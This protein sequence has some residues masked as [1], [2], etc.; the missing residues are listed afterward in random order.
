MNT[1]CE[2]V[3][4][5]REIDLLQEIYESPVAEFV[6]VFGRRRIGKTYLVDKFFAG[7]YDFYMTGIY[8]GTRREQLANFAHQL[9]YYSH[10]EQKTPKDWMEAFFMLRKYAD[11]LKDKKRIVIFIDEMP[12]LD[13]HNA[14]FLKAF[15]LFW[16][17]WASKQ[18]RLKLIVCGSATTWMTNTLLGN[19]GGLHNRV[20]RSIYLRPFNLSDTEEFLT[21]RGFQMQRFQIAELYMVMGGTPFYLNMLNRSKSVAQNIDELFF[22]ANAPLRSEYGFL[23]K[24][25]FKESSLYRRVVEALAKKLKGMTRSELIEELKVEDSGYVSTVLS[26]LCNCDFIRKY[27]AFGKTDR[28][29]M[30]QLTDLYSLFYLKFVKNYHGE[31]EQYW[32]HRQMDIS[33]WEGYAFEQVC[34]HHIPQIKR[35][36]GISGILSNVCT[37]ACRPFVDENG[38]KQPGAQIDLVIERGDKTVNLCEMKFASHPYSVSSDYSA[39]LAKRRELFRQITGTRSTLHLTMIT[40]YGVEH[41]AGWQTIQ[42]EVVLDDLFGRE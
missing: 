17:E 6:A 29:S 11:T 20:T 26:D 19:K 22:S 10:A 15:E 24:S 4:R 42:S 34:L 35:K 27:S 33:S 3:G 28:D 12:W 25:L 9:E 41:N 8:E 30:Y 7:E 14:R 39:W 40:S 2:I 38:C 13:T 23:F 37:W 32:S 18:D 5:Q 1:R 36:L 21:S 31:D 16:N